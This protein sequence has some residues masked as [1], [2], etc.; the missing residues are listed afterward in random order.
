[1]EK[2]GDG[3]LKMKKDKISVEDKIYGVSVEDGK[4]YC[5]ECRSEIPVDED[6]P[7]CKRRVN[8]DKVNIQLHRTLP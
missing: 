8:W 1:L 7:T 6:C 3:G 4:Y 2:Y 5:T